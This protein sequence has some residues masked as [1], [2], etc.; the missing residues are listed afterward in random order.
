[1]TSIEKVNPE[2]R[3]GRAKTA[4]S[5]L[6]ASPF[7]F[8]AFLAGAPLEAEYNIDE[9]E[10]GRN[11]K[12]LSNHGVEFMALMIA[13]LQH[14]RAEIVPVERMQHNPMH[15]RQKPGAKAPTRGCGR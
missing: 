8:W 4:L 6:R 5:S 14:L 9:P 10:K 3:R 12:Y 7:F 13:A 1:L 15:P 2:E 11:R